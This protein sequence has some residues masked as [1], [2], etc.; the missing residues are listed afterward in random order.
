M[1]QHP[2]SS[3]RHARKPSRTAAVLVTL[4]VIAVW[5]GGWWLDPAVGLVIAG[6]AVREGF[7]AWRGEDCGC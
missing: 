5:P 4:A 7:R 1:G 3:P 6:A 2:Q